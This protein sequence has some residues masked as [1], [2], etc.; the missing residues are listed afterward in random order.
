M[1]TKAYPLTPLSSASARDVAHLPPP[2]LASPK[3]RRA[4]RP[5]IHFSLP[6]ISLAGAWSAFKYRIGASAA[7]ATLVNAGLGPP[8]ATE[9]MVDIFALPTKRT[10]EERLDELAALPDDNQ[11]DYVVVDR[12]WCKDSWAPSEQQQSSPEKSQAPHAADNEST[13]SSVL[14]LSL[15]HRAWGQLSHFFFFLYDFDAHTERNYQHEYWNTYKLVAFI[16]SLF[17]MVNWIVGVIIISHPLQIAEK[18]FYYGIAP[19]FS[20]TV[21]IMIAYDWPRRYP[22]L[23]QVWLAISVWSWCFYQTLFI[24]LCSFYGNRGSSPLLD[25]TGKDFLGLLYYATAL[26]TIA[27]FALRHHRLTCA[28][29]AVSFL[30][31]VSALVTPYRHTWIRSTLNLAAYYSFLLYMH[32][33]REE[34]ERRLYLLREE[35]KAQAIATQ[36]AQQ[37]ER[38]AS[39]SK[40]RLTSYIFHEVRVPLNTALLAVQNMEATGNVGSQDIEFAALQGSLSMMSKVLNDVLD[41]NR[42]DAGRFESVSSPYSFH[43]AMRSMFVPLKLA[44]ESRGLE[45]VV[46][47]D[48]DIDITARRA[49]Y[50]ARGETPDWIEQRLCSEEGDDDALVLGDEMRLRQV[51]TNLASNATKFT[52]EG[53]RITI[54]TKLLRPTCPSSATSNASCGVAPFTASRLASHDRQQEI[55][56][57]IIVRIEVADTGFGI[58]PRDIR[59]NKLFSPYVQTEIGRQQGG[60]GSGLG[61]ALVRHIVKLSGGRLGVISHAGHGSCFWVELSL[62]VGPRVLTT[63]PEK[64]PS[65]TAVEATAPSQLDGNGTAAGKSVFFGEDVEPLSFGGAR[66]GFRL[67]D[68]EGV[69][70]SSERTGDRSLF[71]GNGSIGT[72]EGSPSLTYSNSGQAAAFRSIMEQ[73]GRVELAAGRPGGFT[74]DMDDALLVHSASVGTV[75]P[76]PNSSFPSP[77]TSPPPPNRN[78]TPSAGERGQGQASETSET[79]AQRAQRPTFVSIPSRGSFSSIS[80]IVATSAPHSPAVGPSIQPFTQLSPPNNRSRDS[81]GGFGTLRVL[82]VDDDYMTRSMMSRM[83]TRLGCTVSTAEN[84]QAALDLILAPLPTPSTASANRGGGLGSAPATPGTEESAPDFGAGTPRFHIVFLDNQMPVMSGLQVVSRLRQAGRKDLVIGVTGNALLADQQEYLAAGVDDVLTKPVWEKSLREKL[85]LAVE[86]TRSG[87]Q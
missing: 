4:T 7:D 43:T 3:P 54:T 31:V 86:R 22:I 38:K 41:F 67:A 68:G 59:D 10:D 39:E 82:V 49:F 6:D 50:E 16:S 56:N 51:V 24:N 52:P 64:T 83:L 72:G 71:G 12:D 70:P 66:P 11:V 85:T 33:K 21:P 69:T 42:M 78:S 34:N 46:D 87:H 17:L 1:D 73:G 65:A 79:T 53:G 55:P 45:L 32:Y 8:S 60:K 57:H 81:L 25:C 27:V 84:G 26:P 36:R 40:R 77:S 80:N 48:K 5:R 63:P 23:Y 62:G 28:I 2:T 74:D 58:R 76:L 30:A 35:L 14:V 15:W 9:A 37:S 75:V 19:T 13:A 29:S 44:A 47:L 61:L 20:I 18:V